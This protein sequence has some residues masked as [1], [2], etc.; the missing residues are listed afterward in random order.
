MADP[1]EPVTFTAG[2][3]AATREAWRKLVDGVL[4][5]ASFERLGSTTYDGLRIDPLPERR[6]NAEPVAARAGSVPWQ[7]LARI[8]HPDPALA[9][10]SAL[11]ELENG[12][13]GLSL[14]FAGAIG[15]HGF[16]LR[17]DGQTLA[18]VLEGVDIAG[19]AIELDVSPAAEATID[20]TLAKDLTLFRQ[21]KV[22]RIGHDPLGA[23]ALAGGAPRRWT[24]EAPHFARRLAAL[25]RDGWQ[26][27]AAADGRVIH[28]AGGSEVQELAY[29]LSAA[30]SYLRALEAAALPLEQARGMIF[31]RLAADADQFL[32]IAKFRA[33]RKLWARVE[34]ACGL[35]P[36]PAFVSAESAWRMMT[37]RDPHANMLRATIAVF[38]AAA[39]GA[40]AI[41]VLPFTAALG[42]PDAF[43]RRNARNTQLVLRDESNL[44]KVADA[45]A[46][47]GTVEDLTDQLCAAAWTQFQEIEAAGGCA[48]ALESGMI[49]SKVAAVHARRQ[50]AIASG[51]D[52]LTGA[53]IFPA[54]DEVQVA[55]L[56]RMPPRPP[57]PKQPAHVSFPPLFPIRLAAPFEALR[58]ASDK[59]LEASGSRPKIFLACLGAEAEFTPRATFAAN[60]FAA[61]GIEA[62][63]NQTGASQI[64]AAFAASGAKLACLCAADKSYETDGADA[65]AALKAAGARHIYVAS[66]PGALEPALRSAGAQS[67]I[68]EGCDALSLL[69]V[70][71]GSSDPS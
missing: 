6:P 50:A 18:R 45:A 55:V 24:E 60:F 23:M 8:E 9:N 38:V 7:V 33:V 49:Q 15:D 52:S 63:T 54:L 29:A 56:E 28:N 1:E 21:A 39:A 62:V 71:L 58:D 17:P 5:G 20:A 53:S 68:Y 42:L 40:D 70:A 51:K 4:K 16:G 46:G 34:M 2:F 65:A 43:A 10:A 37:Q 66:R 27:L 61:G 11:D 32:G 64:G 47:S 36:V 48:A 26:R 35:S 69:Q 19:T 25:A 30:L 41:G 31:F 59:I 57:A 13:T 67:F 14:V 12:A 22:L 3:P 44:A